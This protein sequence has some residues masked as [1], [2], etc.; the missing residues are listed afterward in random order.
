MK[1]MIKELRQ[2]HPEMDKNELMSMGSKGWQK[3]KQV[4]A[5]AK[6]A[7]EVRVFCKTHYKMG[8]LRVMLYYLKRITP[9]KNT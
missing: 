6:E 2:S 1:N 5:D 4:K 7:K 3:A 9:P 8:L